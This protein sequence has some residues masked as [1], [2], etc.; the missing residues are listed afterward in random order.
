MG[1]GAALIMPATLSIAAVIFPASERP[2]AVAIWSAVAGL[3]GLLGPLASGVLLR[4]F[5]W[6]SVFL[7]AAPM[8][9]VVLVL[10]AWLV[11]T[12]RDDDQRPLDAVGSALSIVALGCLLYGIIEGPEAGLAEPV[13]DRLLR[14]GAGGILGIRPV[15]A[16]GPVPHARPG[17]LP[18][19]GLQPRIDGR[20][21]DLLRPVR[22]VLHPHPVLPVRAGPLAARSGSPHPA[23]IGGRVAAGTPHPCRGRPIR[24]AGHTQVPDWSSWPSGSQRWGR[25]ARLRPTGSRRSPSWS[26]PSGCHS[27]CRPRRTPS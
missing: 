18:Q 27:S 23:P 13:G 4:F 9:G 1:V 2:K 16:P 3:G 6:G 10:V 25:S 20:R 7:V 5:W 19:P 12:S 22:H 26:W 15:G 17:V 14:R 24:S 8:A 21:R 11:P